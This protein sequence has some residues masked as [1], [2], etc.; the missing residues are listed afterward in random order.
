M[1]RKRK[2]RMLEN[3]ESKITQYRYGKTSTHSN[4]DARPFPVEVIKENVDNQSGQAVEEDDD[5][6]KHVELGRRLGPGQQTEL[7]S[8]GLV[9]DR[10]LEAFALKAEVIRSNN[11]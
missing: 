3:M 4:N 6:H 11:L 5:A 8:L 7:S 1:K 10:R 2:A 9:A